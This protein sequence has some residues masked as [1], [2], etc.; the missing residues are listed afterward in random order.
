VSPW[1]VDA[2]MVAAAVFVFWVAARFERRGAGPVTAEQAV[3]GADAASA[4]GASSSSSSS[5]SMTS[6]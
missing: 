5:L 6:P 4:A 1:I 3:A 2:G